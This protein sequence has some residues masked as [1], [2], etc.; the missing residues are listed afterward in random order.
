MLACRNGESISSTY[1][2]TWEL[3]AGRAPGYPDEGVW[4]YAVLYASD[5]REPC[6]K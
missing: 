6:W 1:R 4:T 3:C 2:R 5:T